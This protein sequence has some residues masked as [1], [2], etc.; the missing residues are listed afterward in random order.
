MARFI[1]VRSQGA[2]PVRGFLQVPP[3]PRLMGE[4]RQGIR[5]PAPSP[6]PRLPAPGRPDSRS[7]PGGPESR[8]ALAFEIDSGSGRPPRARFPAARQAPD[9]WTAD[10]TYLNPRPSPHPAACAPAAV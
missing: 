6:E 2:A 4:L 1:D 5:I 7:A 9:A 3:Q 10:R 8:S